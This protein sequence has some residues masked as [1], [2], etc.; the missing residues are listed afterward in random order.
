MTE[1]FERNAQ[2]DPK[3]VRPIPARDFHNHADSSQSQDMKRAISI[4][5]QL[6]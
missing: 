6:A 4:I 5:I 2:T 1:R 3:A